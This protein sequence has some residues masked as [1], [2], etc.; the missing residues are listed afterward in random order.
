M[1]GVLNR[2]VPAM[3][4]IAAYMA[5]GALL[6]DGGSNPFDYGLN[7]TA[8][9]G[10]TSLVKPLRGNVNIGKRKSCPDGYCFQELC[11]DGNWRWRW[12]P[13]EKWSC[14]PCREYRIQQE[15]VPE[16]IE[17]LKWA[18][19]SGVTLKHIVLTGK[20]DDILTEARSC[21]FRG[22]SE[23]PGKV[24][25]GSDP[26]G[27]DVSIPEG[28]RVSQVRAGPFASVG[29]YSVHRPAG[30]GEALWFSCLDIGGWSAVPNSRVLPGPGRQCQGEAVIYHRATAREGVLREV[31]VHG[32][33]G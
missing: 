23:S 6:P 15:L 26:Q 20:H 13:C 18:K 17:A 12:V 32:G 8:E 19:E 33:L 29:S 31:R 14:D 11:S 22:P 21:G 30:A 7:P 24:Q 25:T 2:Q 9:N 28:G 5:A 27:Q 10:P 3:A 1:A 4:D 16:I